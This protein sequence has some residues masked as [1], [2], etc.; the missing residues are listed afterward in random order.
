VWQVLPS[1]GDKTPK[2]RFRGGT[3]SEYFPSG[4]LIRRQ[5]MLSLTLIIL[6]FRHNRQAPRSQ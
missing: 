1:V 4:L 5:I 6:Y 2:F 3:L